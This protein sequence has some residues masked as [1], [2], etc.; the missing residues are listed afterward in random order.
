MV[1]IDADTIATSNFF[2]LA[3]NINET[4][5][6]S[7]LFKEKIEKAKSKWWRCDDIVC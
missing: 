1:Y 5:I 7:V 3:V 2:S 4:L 6:W